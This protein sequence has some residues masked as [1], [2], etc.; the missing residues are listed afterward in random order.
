MSVHRIDGVLGRLAGGNVE[1]DGPAEPGGSVR[2]RMGVLFRAVVP[3]A[4]ITSASVSRPRLR[5]GIGVHGWRGSWLVNGGLGDVAVLEI[6]PPVRV[7]VT[8][9]RVRCHRLALGVEDPAA[10]VAEVGAAAAP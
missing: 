10:L 3:L 4:W 7:W 9:L 2:V 6:D 1:V 8:G 5:D